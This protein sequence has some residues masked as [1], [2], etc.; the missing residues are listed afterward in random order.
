MHTH[1]RS[2]ELRL[3]VRSLGL[4]VLAVAGLLVAG[5][6]SGGSSSSSSSSSVTLSGEVVNVT[7]QGAENVMIEV[8]SAGSG[9]N[10]AAA[11]APEPK[12]TSTTTPN[13][14]GY[15][16]VDVPEAGDYTVSLS[17]PGSGPQYNDVSFSVSV[18]G[19]TSLTPSGPDTLEGDANVAGTIADASTGNPIPGAE[20]AFTFGQSAGTT[21]TSRSNADLVVEANDQGEYAIGSAPTGRYVCVIRAPDYATSVVE[22]LDFNA[23][24]PGDTTNFG[25]TTTTEELDEG[26]LRIVLEWGE[27]PDDL[28]SHLTGPDGSGDRFHVYYLN[29]FVPADSSIA[30]LDIDDTDSFG[31]ETIT[32][33]STESSG[34]YRYSVFNYANQEPDGAVGIDESPARVTVYDDNGQQ[35]AYSPP[36]ADSGDGNTWRVFEFQADADGTIT[37]QDNGGDT[38][39]YYDATDSGDMTTFTPK[40]A[41]SLTPREKAEIKSVFDRP[42]DDF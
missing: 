35:A 38:F 31:P 39:G 42:S 1:V 18:D 20:A 34:T 40:P 14:T 10:A 11:A 28:D 29:R 6:D 3:F 24:A 15:Y 16:E 27:Q 32:L 23:S 30:F 5:C 37:I 13:D 7:G 21:D 8:Q 2:E 33:N 17:S 12:A 9:S 25:Q 41:A 19:D 22:D 26:T 4:T 36:P